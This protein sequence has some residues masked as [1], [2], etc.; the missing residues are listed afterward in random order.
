M[1]YFPIVFGTTMQFNK[2]WIAIIGG[3]DKAFVPKT[4]SFCS[5]GLFATIFAGVRHHF[6]AYGLVRV[7][8]IKL[9]HFL[10]IML[11]SFLALANLP[12][13]SNLWLPA[14]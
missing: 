3:Y 12:L 4:E 14:K 7:E 1:L 5:Y 9:F 10:L 8:E 6:L 11:Y 13:V 2:V